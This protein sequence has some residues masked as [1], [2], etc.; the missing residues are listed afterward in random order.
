MSGANFGPT[1]DNIR[2]ELFQD[3]ESR[4]RR[5]RSV[6]KRLQD[7]S[8]SHLDSETE[9]QDPKPESSPS[10]KPKR[11][12]TRTKNGKVGEVFSCSFYTSFLLL[13]RVS[14]LH[15]GGVL[16]A[17]SGKPPPEPAFQVR[18]IISMPPLIRVSR[19]DCEAAIRE[20]L[21][22]AGGKCPLCPGNKG[23]AWGGAGNL[24]KA[25][26][27]NMFI[28]F[29]RTHRITQGLTY[30]DNKPNQENVEKIVSRFYAK[31]K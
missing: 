13:D 4:R 7:C 18:P 23:W 15:Q 9:D 3:P 10:Q 25:L 6:P 5:T 19:P 12:I 22:R 27:W 11:I 20:I 28:H 26:D 17:S 29:S 8:T 21:E 31:A 16:G 1:P 2:D 30:S 14:A 24:T